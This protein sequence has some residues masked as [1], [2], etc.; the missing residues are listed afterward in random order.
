MVHLTQLKKQMLCLLF[1]CLFFV[2][3][4]VVP[5]MAEEAVRDDLSW[6]QSESAVL[7]EA[8]TGQIILQKD[9][10]K[11]MSPASITK[12]M[13]LLRKLTAEN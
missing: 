10:Q 7:M 5:A 4:M 12:I 2:E 9:A 11:S 13:T 8:E 1:S 6:M 3:I